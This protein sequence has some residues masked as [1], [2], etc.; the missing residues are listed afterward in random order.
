[1]ERRRFLGGLALSAGA[2]VI[3][4]L[5]VSGLSHATQSPVS[6]RVLVTT[7]TGNIGHQVLENILSSGFPIRVIDRDPSRIPSS[8]KG[9]IEVVQGSHSDPAVVDEAFKDTDTVFWLC[10]PD[11]QAESVMAAYVNFTRPACEAII[12]HG[13][14]RVVS[15]SAL[16]RGTPQARN[17]GHV[18]ASLA[19]DDLIANTGV[20]FRALTMSSFMNNIAR[21]ATSISKQGVFFL[22]M[23]GDR[24]FPTVASRDIASVASGLLLDRTWSGRSEVPVLGPEDLSYNDMAKIMSDVLGKPVRYQQVSLDTFKAG[25]VQRGMSEAMAQATSDM[26]QAKNEGLDNAV[27]RTPDNT[28]P[29][30]FRQWC[31]EELRPVILQH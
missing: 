21:Q 30:T 28:T 8:I 19:M 13:V 17:A 25:F 11:P 26:Y 16:G 9:Q 14:R 4:S 2:G 10:P 5:G 27:Q 20:H 18:T 15:I 12:R 1:M 24:K 6:N 29:T 23:D 22:P 31:E 7:P 3:A